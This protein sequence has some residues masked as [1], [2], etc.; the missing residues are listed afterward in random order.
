ML[1]ALSESQFGS[2][3]PGRIGLFAHERV[4]NQ[5]RLGLHQ[6]IYLSPG[7]LCRW[8]RSGLAGSRGSAASASDLR[9]ALA[10]WSR[11]CWAICGSEL[12]PAPLHCRHTV[13]QITLARFALFTLGC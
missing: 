7:C 5:C 1:Q 12:L 3:G 11:C 2:G 4:S 9:S 6:G 8:P 10:V 13:L